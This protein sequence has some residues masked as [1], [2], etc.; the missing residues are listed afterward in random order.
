MKLNSHSKNSGQ[1][2]VVVLIVVVIAVGIW[3]YLQTTNKAAENDARQ[4]GR[5]TINQLAVAYN[6]QWLD[7]YLS[8]QAKLA[9]APSARE[10]LVG[11]FRQFGAPQQPIQIDESVSFDSSMGGL[12]KYAPK[13]TFTAHLNYPG[14]GATLQIATS[15]PETRWQLDDVT[16]TP[17]SAAH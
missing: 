12:I 13:G 9:M 1:G 15:H 6:K 17:G 5:E 10:Y 3:W 8:P 16:F 4:F 14:Q 11:R 2:V 7:Q